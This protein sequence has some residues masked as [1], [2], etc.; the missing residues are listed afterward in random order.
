MTVVN[1]PA[2]QNAAVH[3]GSANNSRRPALQTVRDARQDQLEQRPL[4]HRQ[5][6]HP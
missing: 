5:I 6:P 1:M 4:R 3:H 2:K